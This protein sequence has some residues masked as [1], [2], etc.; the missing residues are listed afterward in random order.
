MKTKKLARIPDG[1]VVAVQNCVTSGRVISRIAPNVYSI[2]WNGHT[3]TVPRSHI[4]SWPSNVCEHG[5]A[6]GCRACDPDGR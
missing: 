3:L 2:L 1:T 6:Q 5:Y 4:S